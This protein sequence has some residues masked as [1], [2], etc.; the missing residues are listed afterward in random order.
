MPRKANEIAVK[1]LESKDGD[2][3]SRV[4]VKLILGRQCGEFRGRERGL[5]KI[6]YVALPLYYY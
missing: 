5:R 1:W 3:I 2:K 6:K 4:N